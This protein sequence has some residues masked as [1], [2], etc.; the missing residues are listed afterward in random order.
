MKPP[1]KGTRLPGGR[2]RIRLDRV[3]AE[4]RKWAEKY[5]I[6]KNHYGAD[7]APY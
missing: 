4:G 1:F 7:G 5:A 3:W 2:R 6:N